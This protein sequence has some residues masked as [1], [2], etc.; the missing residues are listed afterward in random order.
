MRAFILA[1]ISLIS[2]PNCSR[3]EGEAYSKGIDAYSRKQ[4]VEAEPFIR[5]AAERG[6][7]DG[8]SILG[9]ITS[10]DEECRRTESKRNSG[11]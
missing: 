11:S 4:Y 8:M 3:P 10:S 6:H 7:V 9:A 2:L 5:Q 1:I